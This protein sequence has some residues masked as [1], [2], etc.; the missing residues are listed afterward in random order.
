MVKI[1]PAHF[2]RGTGFSA[3]ERI[4]R[5]EQ[6]CGASTRFARLV[7]EATRLVVQMNA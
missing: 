3:T 1:Y 5:G 4:R 7:V 2:L 6:L